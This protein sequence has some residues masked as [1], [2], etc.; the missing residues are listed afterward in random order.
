MSEALRLPG[1]IDVIT[2]EDIPG[3]KVRTMF[4]YDEAL[5][6]DSEVD[7]L[8]PL[9]VPAGE[10][11]SSPHWLVVFPVFRCHVSVRWCVP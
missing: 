9:C 8:L 7:S 6:A 2:A 5:L 11:R 4:G 10:Y 1:V 3:V